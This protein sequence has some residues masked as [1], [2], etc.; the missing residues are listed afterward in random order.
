MIRLP[1]VSVAR[2]HAGSD[3]FA[4]T[5]VFGETRGVVGDKASGTVTTTRKMKP[6]RN[7]VRGWNT[8]KGRTS[9]STARS[10]ARLKGV[11][12]RGRRAISLCDSRSRRVVA[13]ACSGKTD[14]VRKHLRDLFQQRRQRL[15]SRLR[16]SPRLRGRRP[17]TIAAR[18]PTP[19]PA[20]TRSALFKTRIEG[21]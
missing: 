8:L 13:Y 1:L 11:V 16:I 2:D 7:R 18:S 4:F 15:P 14:I 17:E 6:I 20:S 5:V 3:D 19:I 10:R 12:N 9:H 21:I